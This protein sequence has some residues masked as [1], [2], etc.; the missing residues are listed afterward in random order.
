MIGTDESQMSTKPRACL[1]RD[2]SK[3]QGQAPAGKR[4]VVIPVASYGPGGHALRFQLE[5]GK[6]WRTAGEEALVNTASLVLLLAKVLHLAALILDA[7]RII[8]CHRDVGGQCL[9]YF[10]LGAGE[11]IHI[12]VRSAENPDDPVAHFQG[13]DDLRAGMRFTSAVEQL[14]RNVGSVVGLASSHDPGQTNPR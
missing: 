2:I 7:L 12:V 6:R 9:Q 8:D 14:L 3:N 10:D 1:A 4:N 11:G 13:N 5:A